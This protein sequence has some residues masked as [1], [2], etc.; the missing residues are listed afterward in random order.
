MCHRIIG[1]SPI[2]GDTSPLHGALTI[3]GVLEPAFCK[4]HYALRPPT[5]R[6]STKA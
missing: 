1:S 4:R 6:G 5:A 3:F 2:D